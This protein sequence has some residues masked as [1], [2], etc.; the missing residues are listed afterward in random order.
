MEATGIDVSIGEV[1]ASLA[2]VTVAVAVSF[3]RRTDLEGDIA[4]AVV[5]SAIQ[6]I[7]IGYVIQAIFDTDSLALVF[8]LITVM[9][10]KSVV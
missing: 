6:L 7:A 2:Q 1:V 10:R 4:I 9:V 8:G 5:R 3:W